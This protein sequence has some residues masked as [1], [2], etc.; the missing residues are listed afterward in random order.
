MTDCGGA[1]STPMVS[2]NRPLKSLLTELVNQDHELKIIR[3]LS[4]YSVKECR[5]PAPEKA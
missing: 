5:L 3:N 4:E 2:E 1:A